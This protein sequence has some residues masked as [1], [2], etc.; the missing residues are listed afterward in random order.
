M[1]LP[2]PGR[3][4]LA[5][6]SAK[7]VRSVSMAQL[8]PRRQGMKFSIEV[9]EHER[10]RI[11]YHFNQL[12][13]R[14][15]IRVN[16]QPVKESLRLFNEPVV[17]VHVFTVGDTEPAQVRI[18]KERGQLFGQKSRLYVNNRLVRVFEGL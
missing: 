5:G 1:P 8:M 9:G 12:L 14:L 16:G 7:S 4:P 3:C 11:E 10:H 17:E 18:E 2:G 13:G 15:I 6:D